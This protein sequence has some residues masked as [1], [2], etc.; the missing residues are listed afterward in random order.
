MPFAPLSLR[1]AGALALAAAALAQSD[2]DCG[3]ATQPLSSTRP[4]VLLIGDSIS[5]VPPFTPGGYGGILHTLLDQAGIEAQHAGGFFGGGQCSNTVKGLLCTLPSTPNNY[6]NISGGGRFDLCHANWGL[7]DLVAACPKG[8]SGECLE[9]VDIPQ[10]GANLATLYGRL[11]T[12]CDKVMWVSTTPVPNVTTSMGRTYELAVAYNAQALKSLTAAALPD[13]L[14]VD[15]L[16]QAFIG[17]CG[18]Y[19][20]SCDLQLPANVHLTPA[21]EQFAAETAL[22]AIKA[23]LA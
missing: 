23:A 9:H 6:L 12:V 1:A 5:M 8:G 10:Y 14:L 4:N 20:K 2:T 13:K 16:W 3:N 7:H 21:G 18:A 11:K 15:D 19:Y 17:K 22:A